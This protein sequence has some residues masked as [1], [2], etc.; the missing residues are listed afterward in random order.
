MEEG[1]PVSEDGAVPVIE[2][3]N[4]VTAAEEETELSPLR[5]DANDGADLN[6]RENDEMPQ[7]PV[8]SE[9]IAIEEVEI[10]MDEE[11]MMEDAEIVEEV[12]LFEAEEEV[13]AEAAFIAPTENELNDELAKTADVM[14]VEEKAESFSKLDNKD[15]DG[16]IVNSNN[17]QGKKKSKARSAATTSGAA[18]EST[19]YYYSNGSVSKN[20][21]YVNELRV[22]DY[23][24][25]YQYDYELRQS[26]DDKVISSDFA[27]EAD[28]KE[29]EKELET[30]TVQ[31]TY[32]GI[33]ESATK[34]YV[35][36]EYEKAIVQFS[37][38]LEGA[39]C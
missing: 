30:S 19:K 34:N 2:E 1:A 16:T 28:K 4:E 9:E 25:E 6:R 39:S 29:A 11:V 13:E 26:V 10:A 27:T 32:T 12:M 18:A 38:D 15:S 23:T 33:L 21:I 36:Q 5:E 17:N 8:V 7:P 24:S 22:V 14:D 37:F 35:R 3:E 20:T 31:L